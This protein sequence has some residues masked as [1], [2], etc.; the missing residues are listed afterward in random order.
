MQIRQIA[1]GIL[2]WAGLL[3]GGNAPAAAASSPLPPLPPRPETVRLRHLSPVQF[4]RGLLSMTPAEREKALAA[5]PA[6]D[7]KIILA[8][9]QEYEAMPRE[10][11]EARL[12]QTELHWE[13]SQL[14]RLTPAERTNRLGEVSPLYRPM[15]ENLLRQWDEIPA[16]T[17]KDLLERQDFIGLYL[18]MQGSPAAT[19]KEILDRLPEARRARWTEEMARWQALPEEQRSNLCTQFQRFCQMSGAEQQA[20]VSPLSGAE[21]R[22]M[23]AALQAFNRMSPAQRTQCI[24]AFGK[25]A[26]MAPVE[27]AQFLQNAARWES[28]TARERR[29]WR[30]LV[31]KLPPLPPGFPSHMALLPPIPPMPTAR[32][33]HNHLPPLPPDVTAPVIMALSTNSPLR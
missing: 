14:M 31:R 29:L 28:M 26:T 24:N 1:F 15:I 7:R 16:N 3:I 30:Q 22:E 19:Q 11:R 23:K 25:F 33:A 6:E 4:F 21:R 17:Q 27:Q 32:A 18:H 2:M 10:L 12:C 13:L 5:R 9:V 20:T 8:K